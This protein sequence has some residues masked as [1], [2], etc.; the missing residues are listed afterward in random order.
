M[1]KAFKQIKESIT[2]EEYK[3][4]LH[5]TSNDINIKDNSKQNLLRTFTILYFTGLRLNELQQMKLQHIKELLENGVTKLIL[6]KTKSERKL[7]ASKEFK[8]E[9]KT[10]FEQELLNNTN[11]DKRI[12]TKKSSLSPINSDVFIKQVN[13]KIKEILG[14]GYTSHS[15]RQGLITQMASKQIN[16]KIISKFIG[17]SDVKTTMHYI[18]PTDDDVKEAMIR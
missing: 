13:S 17:H 15:F 10:L 4:L 7:F 5:F 1:K 14:T 2:K 9:L 11:L 12:I 3:K 18:K 16:T 8:K 6:P